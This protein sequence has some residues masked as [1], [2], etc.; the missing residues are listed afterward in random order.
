M[1]LRFMM[2]AGAE[3][4]PRKGPLQSPGWRPRAER[5]ERKGCPAGPPSAPRYS[6]RHPRGR[7]LGARP[8]VHPTLGLSPLATSP[9]PHRP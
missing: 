7:R 3:Q 4:L 1:A 8:Q 9:P 2:R 5:P 6:A